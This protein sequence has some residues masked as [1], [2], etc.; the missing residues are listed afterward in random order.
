MPNSIGTVWPTF[1]L[2]VI[3]NGLT[4]FVLVIFESLNDDEASSSSFNEIFLE[5]TLFSTV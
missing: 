3:R 4:S 2:F 5:E 1:V